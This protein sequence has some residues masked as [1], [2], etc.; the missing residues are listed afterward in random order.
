MHLCPAMAEVTGVLTLALT[1]HLHSRGDNLHNRSGL[2]IVHP[3]GV[4]NLVC[5]SCI[6]D[7][8]SLPT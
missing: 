2:A 3:L 7:I 6:K 4:L 5:N 8:G 1:G